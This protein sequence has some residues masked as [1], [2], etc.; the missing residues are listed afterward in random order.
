MLVDEAAASGSEKEPPRNVLPRK[1]SSYGDHRYWDARFE[2]EEHYEWLKEYSYFEHLIRPY[3]RSTHSILELGCGNSRL[4]EGLLAEGVN[5]ITCIDLSAVAVQRMRCRLN[6]KGLQGIQVIQADMLELPFKSE[7]FDLVIEKGTMD[8]LYVDSGDPWNPRSE[9]VC[10]VMKMLKGVHKVLKLD[11][12]FISISF[13]QPHFRRQ[14]FE[15]PYF[16]WSVETKTFGEGFHYFF[17]ILKKGRRS[18]D[19]KKVSTECCTVPRISLFHDD[20]DDENFLFRFDID[21]LGI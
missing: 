7:S 5:D 1:A 16:T 4:S 19:D 18:L 13:G 2:T 10:R 15:A 12:I 20:L 11:G 8:V 14:Q 6:E 21:E 17:N 9:T 3:L